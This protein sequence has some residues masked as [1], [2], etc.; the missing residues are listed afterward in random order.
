MVEGAFKVGEGDVCV[1]AEAFDLVEDGGVGG[2]GGVVAVN[3]AGDDGAEGWVPR[4][5]GADL[6]GG[7]VGAHEEAVA[8]RLAF[9]PGDL[10]GVLCVARGV[11]GG[12][13]E[14]FEVVEVGFDF[15]A[16]GDGVAEFFEDRDDFGHGFDEGVFGALRVVGA[17]EG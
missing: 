9:L 3:F 13:V 8:L 14:G 16:E 2:V 4:E 7:G 10:E 12:E 5:H 6:D 15:G 17:G 11:V 1:D